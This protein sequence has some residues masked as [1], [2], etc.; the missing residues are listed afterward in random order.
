MNYL[1]TILTAWLMAGALWTHAADFTV[2]GNFVNIPVKN[3]TTDGPRI[4]RLQ[5]INDNIIRVQATPDNA[6]TEKQS[7][8]I[9]PQ[10]TFAVFQV[11][12]TGNTVDVKTNNIH[13]LVDVN[14]G[15]VQF[16]NARGEIILNEQNQGG[17]TFTRFT[18]SAPTTA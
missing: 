4:V 2:N 5:V 18:A 6:L 8:I 1:K 10:S 17:K 15:H 14:T 11:S 7:L 16:T 9:V 13:A 3:V 12:Q